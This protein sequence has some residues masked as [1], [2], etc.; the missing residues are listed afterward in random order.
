MDLSFKTAILI[1]GEYH[2]VNTIG[3]IPSGEYHSPLRKDD[4]KFPKEQ[5]TTR[6]YPSAPPHLCTSAPLHLYALK[7]L[8]YP[9]AVL[10]DPINRSSR[11]MVKMLL[12]LLQ[13]RILKLLLALELIPSP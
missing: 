7:S 2:R 11:S 9:K 8:T 12:I 13:D 4:R 3:R 10:L 5:T 1:A 6:N